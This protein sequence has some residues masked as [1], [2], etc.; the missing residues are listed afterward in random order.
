[1]FDIVVDID[2]DACS[3]FNGVAN[4]MNAGRTLIDHGFHRTRH[5]IAPIRLGCF[6]KHPDQHESAKT[7]TALIPTIHNH[8]PDQMSQS[9]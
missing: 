5:K 7:N 4:L 6:R 3:F 9:T 2:I 8:L 1:M